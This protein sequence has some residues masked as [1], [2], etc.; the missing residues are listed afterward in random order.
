M[1]TKFPASV[2]P[3]P[4]ENGVYDIP[5]ILDAALEPQR[6]LLHHI[7]LASQRRLKAFAVQHNW[8]HHLDDP[9][10][11]SA[12]FYAQKKAFDLALLE[13]NGLDPKIELPETYCAALEQGVMMS[14]S[15]DLYRE[16]YPEGD[17]ASAFEKLLTH[18][19]AHRL[20]IRILDGNEDAMGPV[21]FYE[22]F[23]LH[24]ASQLEK[25]APSLPP[26]EIW[27]V[28]EAEDR[29]DY[30]RYVTVFQYFLGKAT[31]HQ[32]VEM[33]GKIGFISWLKE[34]DAQP[35]L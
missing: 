6:S 22:G 1:T 15:P 27:A 16:L 10:A 8:E 21:W 12:H 7:L 13:I 26:D 9:F 24:A 31:I 17:E 5:M 3:Q 4:I 11:R 25:A 14:V 29:Q 30:R 19:M 33:A 32:L 23:A 28:V 20:H 18:E 2:Q 35:V 34:I